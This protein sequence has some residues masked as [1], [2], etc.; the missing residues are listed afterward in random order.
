MSRK[1]VFSLFDRTN[2]RILRL[3][4][5]AQTQQQSTDMFLPA[6]YWIFHS[7]CN[8]RAL[9]SL[10]HPPSRRCLHST[11]SHS[12]S[13][14]FVTF[15]K[16]LFR[17]I[18]RRSVFSKSLR[19]QWGRPQAARRTASTHVLRKPTPP[20]MCFH[21]LWCGLLDSHFLDLLHTKLD[22]KL[23]DLQAGGSL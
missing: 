17:S 1:I 5:Y 8:S 21:D 4:K 15:F 20:C 19:P 11:V 13:Q 6:Y 16:N 18:A 12:A 3:L 2:K 10:S 23:L 7:A 9:L 22:S 14:N